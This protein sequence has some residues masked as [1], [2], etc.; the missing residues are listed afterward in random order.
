MRIKAKHIIKHHP[1]YLSP[2][3][4]ITVDAAAG[5]LMVKNGW[6]DNVDT[7]ETVAPATGETTLKID[8][9]DHGTTD[10]LGG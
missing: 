4:E 6:A 1:Y 2:N 3:D 8:G 7:G 10:T 9:A 5:E